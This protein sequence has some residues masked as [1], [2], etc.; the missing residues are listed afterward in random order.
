MVREV[1][2]LGVKPSELRPDNWHD[3]DI[4]LLAVEMGLRRFSEEKTR[5]ARMEYTRAA[6]EHRHDAAEGSPR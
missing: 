5:E 1:I 2:E 3:S 4:G 6:R